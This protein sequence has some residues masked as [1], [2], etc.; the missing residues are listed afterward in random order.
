MTE[1]DRSI[2]KYLDNV[3]VEL[4]SLPKDE[5]DGILDDLRLHIDEGLKA[6]CG[7]RETTQA[8]VNAVLAQMDPPSAFRPESAAAKTGPN[9]PVGTVAIAMSFIGFVLWFASTA[10]A[11]ASQ[12]ERVFI[13]TFPVVVPLQLAALILGVLSRGNRRGRIAIVMALIAFALMLV[14]VMMPVFLRARAMAGSV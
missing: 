2:E 13:V 7:D 8:D 9:Q 3:N 11:L 1:S 4:Q 6:R 14:G 5:R 12:Q 10:I